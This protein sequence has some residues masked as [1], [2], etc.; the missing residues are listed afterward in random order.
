M[1]ASAS[2]ERVVVIG[3]GC[4][5]ASVAY[6]LCRRGARDVLVLEKEPFAGAGSTSKA[7]GGIRAQFSTPVNVQI[8]MRSIASYE[9]IAEEMRTDPDFFHTTTILSF[10][11]PPPTPSRVRS[12]RSFGLHTR[13]R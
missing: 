9:R 4:I 2:S 10:L 5:G 6:H 7:A 11:I 3:A 12:A 13:P 1:S 8:S